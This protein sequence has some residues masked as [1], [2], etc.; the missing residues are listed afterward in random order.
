MTACPVHITYPSLDGA[1]DPY[2]QYDWLREQAPVYQRPGT[3]DYLVTRY[4]DVA[5]VAKDPATFSSVGSRSRYNPFSETGNRVETLSLIEADPPD[6][7]EKRN[8]CGP[9]FKPRQLRARTSVITDICHALVDRMLDGANLADGSGV[10]VDFVAGFAE[11]LPLLVLLD[12]M[13]FPESD[14]AWLDGW[15]RVDNGGLSFLP[16]SV[17]EEQR[18]AASGATSHLVAAIRSRAEHPTGDELSAMVTRQVERD[19]SLD[20]DYVLDN[21][22]TVIRGGV[23][24]T[25][26]M[27][28]MT[29]LMLLE[30]PDRLARL[31]EA[32]SG[33]PAVL[34][35][36]LRLESPVQWAPRRVTRD[37]TLGGVDIPAGARVLV[38]LAAANRDQTVF[39][40]PVE[41]RPD[42][43]NVTGEIAFGLG[44]HFCLGAPLA[45]LEGRIAFEVLLRRLADIRLVP[46]QDIAHVP[47][48]QFRGLTSL[49]VDVEAAVVD[50]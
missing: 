42:R 36:S 16:P 21:A 39:P 1:E 5:A 26:H 11:R 8:F 29:L 10:R 32:P 34:E 20:L 49:L 30:Q 35:E 9:M 2:P 33:I 19:G 50:A 41:F 46:G 12:I 6:H 40:E 43:D 14:L 27:L 4:A 28:S 31:R 47:S 25:A 13:G 17:Q 24:T 38:M 3:T 22:V 15:S 18:Q 44:T 37:V 48:A 45:R 23:I 7:R